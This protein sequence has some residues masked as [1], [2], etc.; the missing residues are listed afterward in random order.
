MPLDN[1]SA[2]S[3][4]PTIRIGE[5]ELPLMTPNILRL[6]MR[7]ALGG[8]STLE[9]AVADILSFADRSVGYGATADSPIKLGAAI[10]VY[11]GAADA[12][13]EIFDGFITAVEAEVGPDVGP[14]FTMLAGDKLFKAPKTRRARTFENA[15]PADIVRT[16]AGDHGL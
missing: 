9:L 7:E 3:A 2:V 14:M 16:I 4:R 5:Q 12:P 6:R 11:M 15:S 10:K 1:P 13:Q 8:L